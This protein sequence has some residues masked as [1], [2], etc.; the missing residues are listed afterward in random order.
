MSIQAGALW[1]EEIRQALICS[2]SAL[3]LLTPASVDS[4]WVMAE[5]GALW[6]L[7]KPF[8]PATIYATPSDLPEFINRHQCI[9]VL[10]GAG[11]A[12]C[13]DVLTKLCDRQ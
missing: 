2:K 3:V 6:A 4:R 9:E 7:G 13:I 12:K 1:S 11:R 8:V 10:T 5:V